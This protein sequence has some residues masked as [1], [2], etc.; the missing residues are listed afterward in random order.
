MAQPKN[1]MSYNCGG[2][3][4]NTKTW[5]CPYDRDTE[6]I[7]NIIYGYT[8]DGLNEEEITDILTNKFTK[9]IC[10]DFPKL[11]QI[12]F[13]KLDYSKR[14]IAFRTFYTTEG[15]HFEVDYDF[16]FKYWNTKTWSEKM[17]GGSIRHCDLDPD[18][19]WFYDF[20]DSSN[21]DIETAI[22]NDNDY[23]NYNGRIVYFQE[24]D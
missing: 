15:A 10:K 4:L 17:G 20:T 21:K 11:R 12:N 14:I 5:Y 22:E 7:W 18:T 1:K 2:H 19:S 9:T 6:N 8:V 23:V 3:A 16:H 13:E 24:E